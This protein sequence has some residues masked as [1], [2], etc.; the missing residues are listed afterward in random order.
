MCWYGRLGNS[1]EDWH[2]EPQLCQ[3]WQTAS[4][5]GLVSE[6]DHDLEAEDSGFLGVNC[7]VCLV[8][9]SQS[10]FG[11]LNACNTF[12]VFFLAGALHGTIV[13][14]SLCGIG[15]IEAWRIHGNGVVFTAESSVKVLEASASPEQLLYAY[16][17]TWGEWQ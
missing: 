12:G 11:G 10:C 1:A 16:I 7:S 14:C 9:V 3:Q 6:P 4:A 17:H 5:L 2:S 13:L 15:W 8:L